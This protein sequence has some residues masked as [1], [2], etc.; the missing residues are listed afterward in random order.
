MESSMISISDLEQRRA[1]ISFDEMRLDPGSCRMSL[2]RDGHEVDDV[3]FDYH[4]DAAVVIAEHNATPA[5]LVIVKAALAFVDADHV[6][7]EAMRTMHAAINSEAYQEATTIVS[8]TSKRQRYAM[9]AL[10][11]ALKAVHE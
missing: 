6:H 5:F 3:W 8:D 4:R 2:R 7:G 11:A 9:G 10:L 1:A